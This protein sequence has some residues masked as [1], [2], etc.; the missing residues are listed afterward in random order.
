MAQAVFSTKRIAIS[1]NNAQMVGMI[2]GA[3]FVTIFSLVSS[4]QLIAQENYQKRVIS[5]KEK[6]AKQLKTNLSAVSDLQKSY[7]QFVQT[8]ENIIGGSPTG[9]GDR[10]GDNAKIVLDALPS[11]YD[12]PA[13]TSSM[14]KLL[15]DRNF[16]INSINGTDDEVAQG[17][18]QDSGEPKPV[19]MPISVSVSSNFNSI[20]DF[21]SV[22]EKSIRPIQMQTIEL[23]GED[24]ELKLNFDAVSY[25]QPA[26]NLT[27]GTKDVK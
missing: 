4:K 12:F 17:K 10:D 23:Q 27:I 26:K 8:P 19:T 6:A 11:K 2:T 3:V 16:K 20:Q 5:E 18:N 14:E 15:T 22:L 21:L 7:Y 9:N 25:Y 24:K 1:K 13:L